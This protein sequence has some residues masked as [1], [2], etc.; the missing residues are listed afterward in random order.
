M[1]PTPVDVSSS[2]N[3]F[4]VERIVLLSSS[5]APGG[6]LTNA[7]AWCHILSEQA[8]RSSRLPW[9]FLQPNSLMSNTLRWL[10]QLRQG[11]RDP[12]R[13]RRC[14]RGDGRPG[15][16]RR[17]GGHGAGVRRARGPQPA[18]LRTGGDLP[19]GPG[20]GAWHSARQGAAVRGLVETAGARGDALVDAG[21]VRRR[22]LQL[23][24]RRHDRRDHPRFG[25]Y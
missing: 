16:P 20:P 5:A 3:E 4:S 14:R 12:R 23:L 8:V 19:R 22:L 24:R 11:R 25:K 10:P 18:L 15:G 7:I 9:T 2:T 13:V 1:A 6:D 21:R 17:G